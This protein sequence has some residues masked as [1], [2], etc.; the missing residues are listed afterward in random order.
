MNGDDRSQTV[1]FS[2][3]LGALIAYRTSAMTGSALKYQGDLQDRVLPSLRHQTFCAGSWP[4]R[5]LSR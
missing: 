1:N 4:V 2:K 3:Y 5:W